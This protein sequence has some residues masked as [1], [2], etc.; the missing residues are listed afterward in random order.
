MRPPRL[1]STAVLIAAAL[2][3]VVA[4][5]V[6]TDDASAGATAGEGTRRSPS[7]LLDAHRGGVAFPNTALSGR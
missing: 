2:I 7:I 5:Q 4:S 6:P 3:A 1:L